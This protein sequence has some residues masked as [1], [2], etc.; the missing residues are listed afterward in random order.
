MIIIALSL[1]DNDIEGKVVVV[2]VVVSGPLHRAKIE[3]FA[4]L[5]TYSALKLKLN[6]T[7]IYSHN[8]ESKKLK[9]INNGENLKLSK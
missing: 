5:P 7:R 2:V 1:F 8:Q 3:V 6:R 4:H 9:S